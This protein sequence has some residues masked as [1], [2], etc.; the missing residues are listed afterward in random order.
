MLA[1][2]GA[3]I[4]DADQIVHEVQAPGGLAYA[5]IVDRFG[6][7]VVLADGALDRV[8]LASMV[9]G[10]AKALAELQ[11]LTHPFVGQVMAERLAAEA[12][13]DNVVVLDIPLLA[14]RGREGRS[15][16]GVAGVLV[17][18][19]PVEVAVARLVANRGMPEED[20]RRRV[21]AQASRED[22]LALADFVIDNSGTLEELA[23]RVEKAWAWIE[24][25][26]AS[27]DDGRAV[28]PPS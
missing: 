21:A 3:V 10:D 9:F 8:A 4:I 23:R 1:S 15:R 14:E 20:A 24:G 7:D 27:S 26:V 28:T 13:T 12:S 17:V 6:P 19:C 11:A 16:Y 2:R 25:L 18:D 5:G 22:R